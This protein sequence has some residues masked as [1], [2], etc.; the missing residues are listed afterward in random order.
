MSRRNE[1]NA[2]STLVFALEDDESET[3]EIIASIKENAAERHGSYGVS[4][5]LIQELFPAVSK[6]S[7]GGGAR[8]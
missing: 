4:S 7:L 1:D 8:H 3:Q 6:T 2:E 5:T